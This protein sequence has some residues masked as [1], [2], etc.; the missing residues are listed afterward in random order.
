MTRTEH[1]GHDERRLADWIAQHVGGKVVTLSRESRWRPSW[2]ALVER[3]GAQVTLHIRGD[4]GHGYSYPI[5]YEAAILGVLESHGIPVPHV[6]GL[7]DEPVAMVMDHVAGSGQLSGIADPALRRS[8]ID[9]Y[10]DIL[11]AI[12]AIDVA[13]FERVGVRNPADPVDLQMSFHRDR[14]RVY[15]EQLKSKPDPFIAFVETWLDRNVPQHRT[16]RS[17]VTFDAGQFLVRDGRIAALYDF[18]ISHINDPLADLAG[19]RTR[20][21]FE[22]LGDLGYLLSRYQERTGVTLDLDVINFHTVVLAIAANQAIARLVT[23]PV[24][25]AINWRIWEVA[26]SRISI[27]AI[28]DAM[29]VKLEPVEPAG[30]RPSRPSI[31]TRAMSVAID[32]IEVEESGSYQKRMALNL[33]R[34]LALV[35]QFGDEIDAMNLEDAAVLLGIRPRS[36]ESADEM[37]E[38]FV[39]DAGPDLDHELLTLFHRRTERKRQLL[40]EFDPATAP[41]GDVGPYLDRCRLPALSAVLAEAAGA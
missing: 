14:R 10:V 30:G 31:A 5:S 40:P 1:S 36:I 18:E 16:S 6:Y 38:Q 26:G 2:T 19:L 28:A 33:A 22:P 39:H 29:G 21:T 12:H 4:R 8:V 7:C 35:E 20:N 15:R 17:F 32:A 25:D 41:A 34:H 27:S 23:Q 9:Q 13:E 24:P 37:L 3:S 11:A